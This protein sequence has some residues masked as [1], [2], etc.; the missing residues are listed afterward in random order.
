MRALKVLLLLLL[1]TL[2]LTAFAQVPL[3][4]KAQI[5]L[6][7]CGPGD[8]LYSVFGH[9]G[10]RV[11]DPLTNLDV[12]Y[13]YGQ[14]DFD[15]PNFYGKFV[16][17]DLQYNVGISSY[18]DFVYTYQY[19]NRDVFEQF[20]NLT[21]VQKQ[22][23]SDYLISTLQS[24]K[25]YYTYKFIDR[26]CTTKVADVLNMHLPAKIS[27]ENKDRGK[28]NRRI[29][30]EKLH[31]KF[32]ENLGI[33]LMFGYKTD[34]EMYQLF[35]PQQLLEGVAHT[36]LPSGP[37]AQPAVTVFKANRD[38]KPS[39]W[40]NCYTF[41]VLMLVVAA[42]SRKK[43][44]QT[45][46]LTVTGLMGLLF[47]TVGFFSLHE[48]LLQNYNA[49][50]CSPLCLVLLYFL[51]KG[52]STWI[53]RMVYICLASVAV[54]LVIMIN[55]PHLLMVS[56]IIIVTVLILYMILKQNKNVPAVTVAG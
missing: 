39:L 33:H 52:N 2:P 55:K 14:F 13:N 11:H 3:S 32:Y 54:Y 19:Y 34:M 4:D 6:L 15:T 10:L 25:R 38:D 44:V 36:K 31:N 22:Q 26:N 56:P 16:K 24:D 29:I 9:T 12:V 5:S 35:L 30:Y 21:P 48:E 50:L 53:I 37:L 28:T 17:G 23:I 45:A 42:F 40:N 41:I 7:T 51:V 18:E 8:E 47:S 46:S 27:M 1:F 20:L 49:L 43:I